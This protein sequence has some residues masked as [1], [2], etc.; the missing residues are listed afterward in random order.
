VTIEQLTTNRLGDFLLFCQT[1]RRE[2]DDSFLYDE[3]LR[4]FVPGAENPTYVALTPHDD[5]VGAASV[6]HGAYYRRGQKGRFRIFYVLPK[7]GQDLYP[8]LLASIVR[9]VPALDELYLFV[10][11]DNAPM[12]AVLASLGF[13]IERW[14]YFMVRD[15]APVVPPAWEDGYVLRPLVFHQDEE[16]YC[17]VRNLGFASLIGSETPVTPDEV[18]GLKDRDDYLEA[19][20]F[21]LYHHGQPVGV[22]RTSEDHQDGERV[23]NIGPLAVVPDHQGQGL[24]RQL[25]RT[26]LSFGHGI[27]LAT[28]VLSANV[29]NENAVR[30]YLSEGFEA[31]EALVCYTYTLPK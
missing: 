24:G 19:G 27:G 31:R 12:R 10:R 4:D 20:I 29:N 22:V 18:A 11:D 9:Q 25:L 28:S 14:V 3:D 13:T 8:R 7:Y 23:M 1:H 21:L 17:H 2:V 15:P 30:L 5:I 6:L 26:A 16:D